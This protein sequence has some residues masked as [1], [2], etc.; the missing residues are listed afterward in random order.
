MPPMYG[1]PTDIGMHGARAIA[2]V[3]V[4]ESAEEVNA[5]DT[6]LKSTCTVHRLSRQ[7]GDPPCVEVRTYSGIGHTFV[8][9]A[10]HKMIDDGSS[11]AILRHAFASTISWCSSSA[12]SVT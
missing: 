8:M 1:E 7:E 3:V 11:D 2:D 4:S 5:S 12:D 10:Q 9:D 6:E